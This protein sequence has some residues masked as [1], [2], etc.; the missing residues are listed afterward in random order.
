MDWGGGNPVFEEVSDELGISLVHQEE[1][2]IDFNIQRTLP[3]KL[4][5]F[6]PAMAVG[7]LLFALWEATCSQK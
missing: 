6:G 1:D 3:H 4:S 2:K 7:D 5:Q